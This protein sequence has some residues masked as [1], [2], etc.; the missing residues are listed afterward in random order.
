MQCQLKPPPQNPGS[1]GNAPANSESHLPSMASSISQNSRNARPQ[2]QSGF[3]SQEKATSN[4]DQHVLGNSRNALNIASHRI[5]A[6]SKAVAHTI[7]YPAPKALLAI[8][9][10]TPI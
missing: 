1:T 4:T 5:A 10:E 2:L 6:M 3:F 8:D 7:P 9:P